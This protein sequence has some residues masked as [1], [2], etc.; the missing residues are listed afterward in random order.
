M[1]IE[2]YALI[3]NNAHRGAGRARRLDRLA[4]RAALRCA[5]LLRGAARHVRPRP[6]AARART[7]PCAASRAA[8][9][10]ETLVLE[11]DSHTTGG[12][13]RIDRLHAAVGGAHRRRAHRRG[14]ARARA[15]AHGA[16]DPRR[17]RRDRALGAPRR[18]GA[19]RDRRARFAGIALRRA[20]C[21]GRDSRRSP[22]SPSP[23][24][25]RVAVRPDPFRL[26]PAAP[27]ADRRRR[28]DRRDRAQLARLVRTLHA[29]RGAGATRSC[30][31]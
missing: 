13:V 18:R 28:G 7:A 5:G 19:A 4:V 6:L 9:A 27:A 12:A 25:E 29:T 1:R 22:R 17:L 8:T 30:A 31:R 2:D 11:T 3:G 15:H 21:M 16:G 24:G 10:T 20:A 26:A 14:P 23:R